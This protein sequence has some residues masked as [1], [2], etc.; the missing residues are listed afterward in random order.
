MRRLFSGIR[1]KLIVL[2]CL[3]G[4]LPVLAS[5]W[6][7]IWQSEQGLI[8][9]EA[10]RLQNMGEE[11][12]ALFDE[13]FQSR[14]DEMREIASVPAAQNFDRGIFLTFLDFAKTALQYESIYLVQ[15][16]GKGTLGID[17]S[18]GDARLIQPEVAQLNVADEPWFHQAIAGDD[19]VSRPRLQRVPLTNEEKYIAFVAVPI[20]KDGEIAGVVRGGVWLDEIFERVNQLHRGQNASV[21]LIDSTGTP[22]TPAPSITDMSEPLT[23]RAAL[24]I[25]QGESGVDMYTDPAGIRVM[26]SYTYLPLLD[27]GLIIEL[28]EERAVASAMQLGVHLER[29]LFISVIITIIIVVIV[30][31]VASNTITRPVL[32]FAAAIR[33]IAQ[34]DLTPPML[35]VSRKDELGEMARDFSSM[36]ETLRHTITN[37]MQTTAHLNDGSKQLADAADQNYEV[38]HQITQAITQVAHGASRQSTSVQQTAESVAMW[39]RSVEQIADGSREQARQVQHG[40]ELVERMADRLTIVAASA[41]RVA[42]SSEQAAATA[43]AGGEAVQATVEGMEQIRAS[44]NEAAARVGELGRRSQEIGEIVDIIREIAES[45]NLLALNAAIEAAR[46]GEHGRGFAVVAQEVRKLAEHSARSAE[47]IT[48]LIA[49]MQDSMAQATNATTAGLAQVEKGTELAATAGDALTAIIKSVDESFKMAREIAAVAQ[50]IS[51]ESSRVVQSVNEAAGVTQQNAA[52]AE[53]MATA[54]DQMADAIESIAAIS[55]ETAATAEEVA[56]ST[57]ESSAFAERVREFASRLA[58]SANSLDELVKMF[59]L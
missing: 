53:E 42:A 59:K 17:L 27:W 16:D 41:D 32:A 12:R 58:Q 29:A 6:V 7:T 2:L 13:W 35:P 14:L 43:Q 38:T 23:T 9:V 3:I 46:A 5:G 45:T 37:L 26:G 24:A 1:V 18:R 54:T 40:R 20:Y 39:R 31:F 22:V 49:S 4:V 51:Q 34:G 21:Y 48:N 25:R 57:E 33:S 47:Q 36:V 56:A 50:D 44:V 19:A 10:N 30:G 55:E 8:Q 52:A 28:E 11:N 15:P